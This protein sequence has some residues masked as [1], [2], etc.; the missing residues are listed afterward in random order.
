MTPEQKRFIAITHGIA[1]RCL[2]EYEHWKA[3]ED[4]FSNSLSGM[5]AKQIQYWCEEYQKILLNLSSVANDT[6]DFRDYFEKEILN[7]DTQGRK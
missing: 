6:R 3:L 2:E 5:S 1:D 4:E 7:N